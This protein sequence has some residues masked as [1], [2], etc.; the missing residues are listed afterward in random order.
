MKTC[1]IGIPASTVTLFSVN[2]ADRNRPKRPRSRGVFFLIF[3][4]MEIQAVTRRL[5]NGEAWADVYF[6]PRNDRIRVDDYQGDPA[7]LLDMIEK[8]NPE[9]SSKIIVKARTSD[10]VFFER[11]GFKEKVIIPEFF[12]GADVHFMTRYPDPQRMENAMR[13]ENAIILATIR[14]ASPSFRAGSDNHLK[15]EHGL[16]ADAPAI[17]HIVKTS[18]EVYPTPMDDPEYV[19]HTMEEGTRYAV[20]RSGNTPVAVASA[21][22]NRHYRNAEITDCATL[23]EFRGKGYNRAIVRWM[24]EDL[25]REGITCLYTIARAGSFSINKVFYSLGFSFGGTLRNNVRI[26]SGFEDMN[27]WWHTGRQLPM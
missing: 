23:P 4:P 9:W 6:D 22:I 5:E 3:A 13:Q 1:I 11:N 10:T 24:C 27:V 18:F 7:G 21:E 15:V 14:A 2:R 26:G 16:Y 20:I 25:Q 19:R 12:D 17:A 8:S